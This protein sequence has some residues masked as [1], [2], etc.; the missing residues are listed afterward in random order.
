M[1]D[2]DTGLEKG[3]HRGERAQDKLLQSKVLYTAMQLGCALVISAFAKEQEGMN[4]TKFKKSPRAR[5]ILKMAHIT[6]TIKLGE[7]PK[8]TVIRVEEAT[9]MRVLALP[10]IF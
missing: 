5:T 7:V 1:Q 6:Q 4:K 2:Y 9:V 10:A 8:A 3:S